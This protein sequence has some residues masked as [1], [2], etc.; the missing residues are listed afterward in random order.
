MQCLTRNRLQDRFAFTFDER[1][2]L[3]DNVEPP[4]AQLPAVASS[5]T[6]LEQVVRL[7]LTSW[8]R[9]DCW[10]PAAHFARAS[11]S[12]SSNGSSSNSNGTSSN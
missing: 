10:S 8:Y 4:A 12:S 5:S 3:F 2:Y 1:D 6:Y 9:S 7:A 11:N